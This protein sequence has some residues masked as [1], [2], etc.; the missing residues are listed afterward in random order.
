MRRC[1]RRGLPAS[2]AVVSRAVVSRAV[3]SLVG[4]WLGACSEMADDEAL[5]GA[6]PLNRCSVDVECG[7]EGRCDGG[8]CL[9]EALEYDSVL[10]EVTVPVTPS[11]GSQAGT[12][13]FRTLEDLPQGG[14]RVEV[15]VPWFSPVTV[16]LS[17]PPCVDGQGEPVARVAG[18]CPE[19][20]ASASG[21]E[22]CRYDF[23]RVPLEVTFTPAAR[24][25]G[26]ATERYTVL[27]SCAE[28]DCSAGVVRASLPPGTY[29]LYLR[30]DPSLAE[31][32]AAYCEPVPE[33]GALTVPVA[34]GLSLDYRLGEP[35]LLP[36]EVHWDTSH[37]SPGALEG[38]RLDMLDG[39]SARRISR[40]VTLAEPQVDD[41]IERYVVALEYLP[42]AQSAGTATE[43]VRLVPPDEVV[44][45]TVLVERSSLGLF[46]G[47][48]VLDQLTALPAPVEVEGQLLARAERSG[49]A[50]LIPVGGTLTL[51]ATS[52][53]GFPAGTL[54]SYQRTLTA[55]GSGA[56]QGVFRATLLP[57]KYRL[58]ALPS[59]SC[60]ELSPC[61]AEDT[62]C[63]CPLGATELEGFTVA[64]SPAL[65]AGK[66]VE[67]AWRTRLGGRVMATTGSLAGAAVQATAVPTRT[68]A[69]ATALG[70]EPFVPRAAA[71]ATQGDGTFELR[72]DAGDFNLAVRPPATSGFA[73]LVLPGVPVG[74]G[75]ASLE[76]G[77]LQLPLPVPLSGAVRVPADPEIDGM[78]YAILPGAM[79]R[80]FVAAAEG[81]VVQVAE[82]TADANGEFEL[83][84]PARLER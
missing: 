67:L 29:D 5:N 19:G 63:E 12:R 1:P 15:D 60:A 31:L 55:A 6:E 40:R 81:T 25:V 26:I 52:L 10:V 51:I 24:S 65:Q 70:M 18:V 82:T 58:R 68:T 73:W 62:L 2:C 21:R 23:G 75:E 46:G 16:Q 11:A 76:L 14:G 80:A 53:D 28:G 78:D 79:L 83:L 69:L 22:P 77:A 9:G 48:A 8:R 84:L 74:L 32:D 44:A 30:P 66:T 61:T 38:W 41:A 42:T 43:L 59:G 37:G 17:A 7:A 64:P 27:S 57:G 45:P 13:S 47:P 56:E 72:V 39:I 71:A 49:N 3:V 36:V 20:S 34:A 50:Q 35:A 33:L 4:L 54:A